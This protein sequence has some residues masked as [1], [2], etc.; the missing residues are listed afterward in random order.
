MR[1]QQCSRMTGSYSNS[2]LLGASLQTGSLLL[3]LSVECAFNNAVKSSPFWHLLAVRI[4]CVCFLDRPVMTSLRTQKILAFQG[5]PL[6]K[7]FVTVS[8]RRSW[9]WLTKTKQTDK[10]KPWASLGLV[11]IPTNQTIQ[12]GSCGWVWFWS[13][14]TLMPVLPTADLC[15]DLWQ[16][17]DVPTLILRPSTSAAAPSG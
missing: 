10:A 11:T 4:T 15:W 8:W 13:K 14:H 5:E 1:L 3:G 12:H 6:D 17:W 9:H 16:F 2:W 7:V